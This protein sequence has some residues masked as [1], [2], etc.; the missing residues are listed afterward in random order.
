LIGVSLAAIA[1]GLAH[2]TGYSCLGSYYFSPT[3]I[4]ISFWIAITALIWPIIM[5]GAGIYTLR[6]VQHIID[7]NISQILMFQRSAAVMASPLSDEAVPDD[8]PS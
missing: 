4:G 7:H 8:K 5:I 2:E 6:A 1:I 3:R